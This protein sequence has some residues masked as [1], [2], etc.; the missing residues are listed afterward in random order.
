MISREN[1]LAFVQRNARS[2]LHM[3]KE[4]QKDPALLIMYEKLISLLSQTSTLIEVKAAKQT[5]EER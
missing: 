5:L 2:L 3:W 4:K 1:R